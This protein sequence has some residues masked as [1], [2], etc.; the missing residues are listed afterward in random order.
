MDTR[1]IEA[2]DLITIS[3]KLDEYLIYLDNKNTQHRLLAIKA[4]KEYIKRYVSPA[5][6]LSPN[7]DVNKAI[8]ADVTGLGLDFL[9]DSNRENL[10]RPRNEEIND[11][12]EGLGKLEPTPELRRRFWDAWLISE[13]K[14]CIMGLCNFLD[15]PLIPTRNKQIMPDVLSKEIEQLQYILTLPMT[16]AFTQWIEGVLRWEQEALAQWNEEKTTL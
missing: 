10:S 11:V 12:L 16:P 13:S 3:K 8:G 9:F 1:R 2:E 7:T 4:I 15:K 5:L 14:S 6:Y